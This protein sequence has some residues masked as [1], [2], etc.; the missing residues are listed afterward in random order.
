[1]RGGQT[2]R[3]E[4]RVVT[5]DREMTKESGMVTS[6]ASHSYSQVKF[7]SLMSCKAYINNVKI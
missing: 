3:R 6:F 4:R 7:L 2:L 1:M 5:R